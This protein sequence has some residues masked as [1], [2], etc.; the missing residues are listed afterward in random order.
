MRSLIEVTSSVV[1][2]LTLIAVAWQARET[3]HQAK[4]TSSAAGAST[5][6]EALMHLQAVSQ[7]WMARP[8]LR[9][10]FDEP[11][12]WPA[13]AHE[14]SRL[15]T[16]A[17]MWADC[18]G[19]AL[20]SSESVEAF[21]PYSNAWRSYAT[22]TLQNSVVLY[23]VVTEHPDWWPSLAEIAVMIDPPQPV[24]STSPRG[25]PGKAADGPTPEPL[26]EAEMQT[27]RRSGSSTNA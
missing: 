1:L 14:R 6:R 11:R 25:A 18:V 22:S 17:E 23:A 19:A 4:V 7:E 10:Y 20:D 21:M 9:A 12:P 8:D 15:R 27:P 3:A 13:E 26:Q 24:P 2:A 5:L 16:L